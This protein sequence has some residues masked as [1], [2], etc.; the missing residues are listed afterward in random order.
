MAAI[1][2]FITESLIQL[3]RSIHSGTKRVPASQCAYYR[4]YLLQMVLKMTNITFRM[5]S[6]HIGTQ[7]V[8]IFMNE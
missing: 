6:M 2:D 1:T 5:D 3:T 8:T 7:A 4:P